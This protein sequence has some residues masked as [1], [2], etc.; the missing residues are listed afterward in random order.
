[1]PQQDM[2]SKMG[3][4]SSPVVDRVIQNN[5]GVQKLINPANAASTQFN[6]KPCKK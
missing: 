6:K 2:S 4:S 3:K 1:M 5:K